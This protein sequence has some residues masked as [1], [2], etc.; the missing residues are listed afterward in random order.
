MAGPAANVLSLIET[1]GVLDDET[2]MQA[3]L[4]SLI[5]PAAPSIYSNYMTDL[6]MVINNWERATGHRIKAPETRVTGVVKVSQ[7]G[8]RAKAPAPVSKVPSFN[9]PKVSMN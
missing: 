6:L 9:P 2:K 5:P 3:T 1:G 4:V 8:Q 7:D